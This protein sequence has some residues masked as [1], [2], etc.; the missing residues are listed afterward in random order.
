MSF[1]YQLIEEDLTCPVC[2]DLFKE[3]RILP[4]SHSLCRKC[5]KDLLGKCEKSAIKGIFF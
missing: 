5:L 2:L 1:N 4:C 3:P